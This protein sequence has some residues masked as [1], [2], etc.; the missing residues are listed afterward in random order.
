M[1]VV[2]MGTPDFAVPTLKAL[3]AAGYDIAAVVTQPDK[4]VGR[5]MTLTPPAVKTAAEE[6]GLDVY[7][8]KSVNKKEFR[9]IIRGLKPDIAV[10]LAFGQILRPALLNLFP[11]GCI[12]V[13]GSILPK[14]RGAA[15]VQR[16]IICGE[17]ETGVSIMKMDEGLDTGPVLLTKKL[18]I[19]PDETSGELFDRIAGLGAEAML[20]ALPLIESGEAVFAEQG[21]DAG[22]YACKLTEADAGIDWSCS[23]A[24]IHNLVRGLNPSPGACACMD[25]MR[26]KVW[27]TRI[28]E[29]SKFNADEFSQ[30]PFGTVLNTSKAG[31]LVKTGS[32]LI[33]ITEVQPAG[34]K[35]MAAADFARGKRLQPCGACFCG[36]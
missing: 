15:P 35:R 30:E 24:A 33:E 7:Q 18:L 23:A 5:K 11:L 17:A 1:K 32:G 6:L 3:H 13:H 25:G 2:F 29:D 20:E 10:V 8:P 4:P 14:Y 16:A 21:Q 9:D 28:P 34:G 26:V 22:C 19:G 31:I 12:N 27:R 36:I